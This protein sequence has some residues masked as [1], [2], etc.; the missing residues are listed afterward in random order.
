VAGKIK[1]YIGTRLP[2][3]QAPRALATVAEGKSVGKVILT[4]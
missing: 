3:S 2:L 4:V 1:T